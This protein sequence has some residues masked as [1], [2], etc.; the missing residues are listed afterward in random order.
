MPVANW[1]DQAVHVNPV[2]SVR[3]P[4]QVTTL[5]AAATTLVANSNFVKL[6]GDAGANTLAT[7][8]GGAAYDGFEIDILF[9]DGLVT[10]TDTAAATANTV[11]LS[12]AFVST[13]NAMLT[14]RHNGTKWYEKSR[15]VNS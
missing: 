12:A 2:V 3:S 8:V 13:A 9:L 10:I 14:L 6:A 15:S 7:L 5:A 11:N 1:Y 4:P